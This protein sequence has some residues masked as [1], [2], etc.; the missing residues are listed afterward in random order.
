M[1]ARATQDSSGK[2][3]T[4]K[5]TRRYPTAQFQFL[6]WNKVGRPKVIHLR[7]TVTVTRR[8]MT[9][10]VDDSGDGPYTVVG[11]RR[12]TIFAG[13]HRGRSLD[14]R[15]KWFVSDAVRDT[16][17]GLWIENGTEYVLVFDLQPGEMSI[18]LQNFDESFD[19]ADF[20]KLT[21]L[22]ELR[23]RFKEMKNS[24]W[25]KDEMAQFNRTLDEEWAIKEKLIEAYIRENLDAADDPDPFADLPGVPG[26]ETPKRT[27][28]TRKRGR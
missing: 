5:W 26:D 17:V 12:G 7:G 21:R 16:Y 4:R 6:E 27:R 22:P 11:T 18:S 28:K 14:V 10:E 2:R 1:S 25:Y 15:A 19:D 23:R 3:R 8:K 24:D 20:E 13:R 9:L